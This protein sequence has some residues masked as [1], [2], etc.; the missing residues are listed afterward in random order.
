MPVPAGRDEHPVP[1][2]GTIIGYTSA[3]ERRQ[4]AARFVHQKISR[5]KVPIVAVAAGKGDVE[6]SLRDAGEAERQRSHSRHGGEWR[7][8]AASRSKRLRGPA[9]RASSRSAPLVAA[10]GA[11]LRVAPP[12]AARHEEILCHRRIKAGHNRPAILDQRRRHR[13]IGQAGDIGARAVDRIDDPD[14]ARGEP[15]RIVDAFLRQPG[16]AVAGAVRRSRSRLSTAISASLTGEEVGPLVQFFSGVPK[17]RERQCARLAD[18]A[19]SRSA[20]RVQFLD[21]NGRQQSGPPRA[22]SAHW[23]R[24]GRQDRWPA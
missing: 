17:Q 1:R 19:A 11:P 20:M 12:S 5:R 8:E 3:P 9:M 2:H 18:G 22:R 21:L 7:H 24:S 16:D 13:P 23:C 15:R 6:G 14:M 4:C 10:I